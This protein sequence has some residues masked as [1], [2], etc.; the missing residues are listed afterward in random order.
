MGQVATVTSKSMV[1]IP[2]R[3]R[4]KYGIREGSKVEFVEA[5][6]GIHMIPLKSLRELR[7][8]FKGHE[9]VMREA[10]RELEAEHRREA[11]SSRK[12]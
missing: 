11:R 2:A 3:I 9:K 12:A 4:E 10:F 5:E 8:A 6:D 7:G 1:T